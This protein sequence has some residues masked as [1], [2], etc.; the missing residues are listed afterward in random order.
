MGS[1]VHTAHISTQQALHQL[2]AEVWRR[3]LG[4]TNFS[5]FASR[6]PCDAKPEK[7]A[8]PLESAVLYANN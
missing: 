7:C 4:L 1:Q 2:R 6:T 8:F 3:G 5:D